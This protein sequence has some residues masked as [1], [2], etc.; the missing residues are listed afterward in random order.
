[1]NP[2]ST[3]PFVTQSQAQSS[4]LRRPHVQ[5]PPT[6]LTAS[7]NNAHLLSHGLGVAQTPLSTTSLSSPFAL[8]HSPYA[9]TTSASAMAAA[10]GPVQAV[11]STYNPQQWGRVSGGMGES[12]AI[13][14]QHVQYAPRLRGPDG[15]Q[16]TDS[17]F[18]LATLKDVD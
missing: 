4:P 16:K 2:Q 6:L 15:K 1:M 8:G 12:I 7:I 9:G 10:R 5:A 18:S 3:Y 11:S 13:S 17:V 14:R